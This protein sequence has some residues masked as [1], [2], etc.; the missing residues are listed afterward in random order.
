ME[1]T[2]IRQDLTNVPYP[3]Y[4]RDNT[5]HREYCDSKSVLGKLY[6]DINLSVRQLSIPVWYH[7]NCG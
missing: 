7:S 3:H 4:L 1:V 2:Q 6:A 5:K